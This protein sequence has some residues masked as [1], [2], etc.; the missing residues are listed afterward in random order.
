[1]SVIAWDGKRLAADRRAIIGGT[2]TLIRTLTKIFRVRDCLVGYAG[3]ACYGEEIL[4][5][6]R[7]GAKPET[8]PESQRNEETNTGLLV[9]HPDGVVHRFEMTPY[10][11]TLKDESVAVGSGRE[12]AIAAMHCG[13]TATE[14]VEIACLFDCNC[15]NGVD[16]LVHRNKT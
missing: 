12:F 4:A 8:F 15:G 2:G 6:F 13:K 11:L 16:V 3:G 10:P 9:I 14:A 7:D 5:W 1:M